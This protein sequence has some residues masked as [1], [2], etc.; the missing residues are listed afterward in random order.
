MPQ[1]ERPERRNRGDDTGSRTGNAK[2][3]RRTGDGTARRSS[4]SRSSESR[5]TGNTGAIRTGE[6]RSTGNTGTIHS[7]EGSSVSG[8]RSRSGANKEREQLRKQREA[9]RKAQRQRALILRGIVF[10]L[11]IAV[12]IVVML[13][14]G[15]LTRRQGNVKTGK[16]GTTS[17]AAQA[18]GDKK[19]GTVSGSSDAAGSEAS[20]TESGG[21]QSEPAPVDTSLAVTDNPT[22]KEQALASAKAFA[23]Q[24]DY[25]RAIA[26][27][28]NFSGYDS[29]KDLT[30]A[31]DKYTSEKASCTAADVDTVG[32]VFFHSLLN[33]DRG[34]RTDIVGSDRAWRNDA[35]MTTAVEFDN[36]IQQMYEAGYVLVSLDDICIKTKNDDGSTS[37]QRNNALML[38]PGKKPLIMSEDDLSYYHTYGIGT[39]GYATKM[40]LDSNGEVKCEY[41]DENGETKIG[42]YDMVPRL[43]TFVKEHPDFSYKGAKATVA[44]TGYNG[45]FGYRTNDY[46]KDINNEHLDKDQVEWLNEHPDFD[47]DKDV[48]DAKAIADAMK[49]NG[50]TFASHTYGHWNASTHTAEQLQ[51]DNERWMTCNHNIVGDIDKIIFAFGGDIGTVGG[52]TAD[53]DK[54]QYFKSQGYVIYCN[55]DGHIG[56]TEFGPDYVRTGRVPL[57][58]FA[59]YQAMTE[60]GGS[61][62]TYAHDFEVLG[63]SNV[64]SFFNK[65]RITPIES[66]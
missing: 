63:I 39:Q 44:L 28:Q 11:L 41:T 58:G 29:D 49:E 25:D 12:L 20:G 45:V 53:N 66:E 43:D 2:R 31:I 24:Y 55:V 27:I 10:G 21:T 47:W 35:A 64:E 15:N 4:E 26:A 60:S 46:Y 57:D 19:E 22:S 42:D 30:S 62:G 40:V 52:Y 65:Y 50:W 16:T 7:S 23:T 5:S 37:V 51:T 14:I 48:A 54:F 9:R 8:S 17:T 3:R 56:W 1:N 59:M 6:S 34:L 36:M 38:P 18:G 13:I 33:D 61:H 32:H